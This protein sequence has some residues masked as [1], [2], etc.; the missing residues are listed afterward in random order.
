M[1]ESPNLSMLPQEMPH[2]EL[3]TR[4]VCSQCRSWHPRS[5]VVAEAVLETFY[6]HSLVVA[7][8]L[9]TL[10]AIL[11]IRQVVAV[12]IR[13]AVAVAIR[14]AVAVATLQEI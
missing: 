10:L 2:P 11:R 6:R 14:Q 13:Q 9:V 1:H 4:Q 5:Q 7:V 12:A 3:E 8:V